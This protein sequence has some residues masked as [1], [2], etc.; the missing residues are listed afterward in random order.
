MSDHDPSRDPDSDEA[1]RIARAQR[2]A[3]Q[4]EPADQGWFDRLYKAAE[5]DPRKVP[6]QQGDAHPLLS[7]WLDER[8][9]LGPD[10]EVLVIGCG[11]GNDAE[12]VA[13]RGG[14]VTAFD[15]SPEAIAW[16]RRLHPDS[17]VDYQVADLFEPPTAWRQAF[18]LVVEVHTV[19]AMPAAL[20]ARALPALA[21][22]VAPGGELLAIARHR[23]EGAPDPGPPWALAETEWAALEAAGLTRVT[24]ERVPRKGRN[25]RWRGLWRR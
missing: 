23:D 17:P 12:A 6:W 11:L 18:A 9:A 8:G 13:A 1:T 19:Q 4:G 21:D 14:R 15:L 10:L 25:D 5:G 22:L 20:R 24:L 2:F 16:A 7:P 3:A